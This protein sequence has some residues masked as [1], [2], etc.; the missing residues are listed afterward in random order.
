MRLLWAAGKIKIQN[1]GSSRKL[2]QSFVLVYAVIFLVGARPLPKLGTKTPPVYTYGENSKRSDWYE[3][4]V[5]RLFFVCA[6]R[7]CDFFSF[8]LLSFS[9]WGTK[10]LLN[11]V[12]IENGPICA[13]IVTIVYA[14]FVLVAYVIFS[15]M[16]LSFSNREAKPLVYTW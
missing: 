12:K 4:S 15:L 6:G 16:L 9:N 11:M 10:P 1:A 14:S 2:C 7:L 5:N 8:V 13:K 3:N